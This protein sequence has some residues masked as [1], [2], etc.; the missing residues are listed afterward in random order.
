MTELPFLGAPEESISCAANFNIPV[1]FKGSFLSV[2]CLL[3]FQITT[4]KEEE[5]SRLLD[6]QWDI[7]I[8]Y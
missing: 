8:G 1:C 4:T 6:P 5:R 2:V 7:K 3:A